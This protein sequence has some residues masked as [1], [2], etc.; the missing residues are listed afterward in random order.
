M[1]ESACFEA[2]GAFSMV[3]THVPVRNPAREATTTTF[4]D[5]ENTV[6]TL[7]GGPTGWLACW[8]GRAGLG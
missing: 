4:S 1:V 3:T 2:F 8:L 7:A 6:R 5:Q